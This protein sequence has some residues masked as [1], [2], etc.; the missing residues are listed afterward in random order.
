MEA[1]VTILNEKYSE[2]LLKKEKKNSITDIYIFLVLHRIN[3][4]AFVCKLVSIP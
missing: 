2:S 3:T 1:K 4:V